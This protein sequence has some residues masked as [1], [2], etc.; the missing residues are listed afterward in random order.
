M[1]ARISRKPW[2]IIARHWR[3]APPHLYPIYSL[4]QEQS[5]PSTKRHLRAQRIYWKKSFRKWKQNFKACFYRH[6]GE[7]SI[8]RGFVQYVNLGKTGMKVS[9]LCLGM[10]SYGSK[11]WREWVLEGDEAKPFIKRALEAGINFFDTA[12][13]YSVGES[14]CI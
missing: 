13:V 5:L 2:K 7:A 1:H 6:E 10:M 3:L 14:E 8:R 4:R 11:Q 12:D 9:R